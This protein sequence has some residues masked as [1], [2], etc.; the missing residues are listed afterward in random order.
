[1]QVGV[2]L[3]QETGRLAVIAVREKGFGLEEVSSDQSQVDPQAY[4]LSERVRILYMQA[5]VTN[6]TIYLIAPLFYHIVTQRLDSGLMGYWV[7]ALYLTASIRLLLW[8]FWR[9]AKLNL[10]DSAWL[11]IY[12]FAS[13]LVGGAWCIAYPLIYLGNDLIVAS[14]LMMLLFGVV[15][16]GV[17][18]LSI[19]MPAF[20]LYTYPQILVLF[21]TLRAFDN[22]TY[23]WMSWGV[24]IYLAMTTLFTLKANRS[25]NHSIAIQARNE[26]LVEE[27]SGEVERRESL[28][29][30]RTL[31]LREKNRALETEIAERERI[32]TALRKSQER[33]DL[34]MQGAND[35]VFDWNLLDN[36]IYYSPRWKAMLGYRDEELP[37]DLSA[38]ESLIDPGDRQLSL[39]MLNDYIAGKRDNYRIEI[40]M[41]H[42]EGHWVDILSRAF[43]LR[44]RSGAAIRIVGTH[45]DQ[46]EQKRGEERIRLLSQAVEQS[47]V[48]VVITDAENRIQYVNKAF[49]QVT[50]YPLDEVVGRDPGLLKSG[51]TPASR[52]KELW[53]KLGRGEVWTGEFQNRKRNGEVYWEQ[54]HISPV[55]NSKGEID[56]YLAVKEDI[57]EK[58]NQEERILKQAH[59]DGLTNLPNRFLALDRLAQII[60]ESLRDGT[61]AAVLFLDLDGFK[62]INDSLGHETGDRLLIQ[63]SKRLAA[64]IR[65][66][67]TVC[68]LGGDEFIVILGGLKTASDA[69]P[70]AQNLLKSCRETYVIDGRELVVTASIGIAIYPEDGSSSNELL[71]NADTA[72]YHSKEQGRNSFNFYTE[73]MNQ[74]VSRRLELEEQ[75]RGALGRGELTLLYQPIIN[76]DSGIV[77]GAE[78]LL[79]WDNPLLGKVGPDEF[80]T[81][82]EQTGSINDIGIYVLRQALDRL[83]GWQKVYPGK[84]TIAVNISPRQFS[85]PE[86]AVHIGDLL[87]EYQ[88]DPGAVVLEITEGVLLSGQADV[89]H[90][91]EAVAALGVNV[92]MDD[93]GTGYSSLSYLRHYPFHSLKIDRTFIADI[94]IDQADRE[95]VNAAILMAHGLGLEVIAEGVENAGQLA[96]LKQSGCELGQGYFFSE[97]VPPQTITELLRTQSESGPAII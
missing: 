37:N 67:D 97:P 46:S 88:V 14:A 42:K 75:L 25:L 2:H 49:E 77:V 17:P 18:V 74:S 55:V 91:L 38:W 51:V 82:A 7:T 52:Y 62:R 65:A 35:G 63:A 76:L 13:A 93:F 95:L 73:A 90:S 36:T 92:S 26:E 43:L 83:N 40:R 54:A 41:R 53:A 96:Y 87:A 32:Q 31:E 81:V 24:L 44:D 84:F 4:H 15:G 20:V 72:M 60:N 22:P 69:Q 8:W 85:D 28:I 71:R 78:A 23:D 30:K 5:P 56:H 3:L 47:P 50:G 39:E 80:I 21:I 16:S 29:E 9:S 66:G 11:R 12:L 27:L 34:A 64:S 6:I 57:T 86:L 59:Y 33:F 61:H 10:S 89:E 94:N 68:R 45:V 79:R 48:L 1:M 58:K 70:V 19:Y